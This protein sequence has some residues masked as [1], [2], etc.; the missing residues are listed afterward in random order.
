MAPKKSPSPK[1]LGKSTTYVDEYDPSLLDPVP[2]SQGRPKGWSVEQS[3]FRGVDLWTLYELSWLQDDGRPYVA[4][5]QLR[6]PYDSPNLVESKSLKLYLNSLNQTRFASVDE[7]RETM[8]NDISA[9]VGEKVTVEVMSLVSPYLAPWPYETMQ[10][11]DHMSYRDLDD[12]EDPL[13]KL[14]NLGGPESVEGVWYTH[15]FRSLCPV[16]QQPDWA[17]L[18]FSYK[19]PELDW[20]TVLG[21]VHSFR[22]HAAFHEQCVETIFTDLL[23]AVP[24]AKLSVYACF[25]RRGG[26]DI[27]P[28][29]TNF[30]FEPPWH[31]PLLRQ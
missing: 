31:E 8:V 25:N 12:N 24:S 1:F 7:A 3:P 28:F 21:Y 30:E 14:V 2:R 18:V 19:G 11:M 13:A 23:S 10:C 15:G 9:C 27:N 20:S 26:I 6:V 16:T 29:R 5:G 22:C 4:I 17:T